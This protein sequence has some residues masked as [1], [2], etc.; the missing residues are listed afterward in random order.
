MSIKDKITGQ[1]VITAHNTLLLEVLQKENIYILS[2]DYDG[3][4][5]IYDKGDY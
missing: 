1:L 3:N 4:N 2:T 5:L